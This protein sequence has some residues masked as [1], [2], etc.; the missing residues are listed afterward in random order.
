[1][2]RRIAVIRP[3]ALLALLLPL[4]GCHVVRVA[5]GEPGPDISAVR[6]GAPCEVAERTFGAALRR[7]E[8]PRGVTLA[9]HRV[10]RGV[11]PNAF[12]AKVMLL[13][14]VVTFG[15]FELVPLLDSNK[16]RDPPAFVQGV[17]ACDEA[18]RIV[19]L[20]GEFDELP[21]D[22][23]SDRLPGAFAPRS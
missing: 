5:Q 14:D 13:M 23:R 2:D 21:E 10:P 7:W 19:G 16:L 17:V 3:G 1:V 12:G 22:G 8:S 9:M 11:P 6:V 4:A 20:F 18:G 15:G